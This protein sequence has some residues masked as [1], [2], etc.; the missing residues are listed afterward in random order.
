MAKI[1]QKVELVGLAGP[2]KGRRLLL[3]AAV[4]NTVGRADGCTVR[5]QGELV[6]EQHAVIQRNASRQW[7]ITNRSPYGTLVNGQATTETLLAPSSSIQVGQASLFRFEVTTVEEREESALVRGIRKRPLLVVAGGVYL[8]LMIAV[9]V[10]LSS[11]G[12]LAAQ[13]TVVSLEQI[14]LSLE[15]TDRYLMGPKGQL[16][17]SAERPDETLEAVRELMVDAWALERQERWR[18][19]MENYADVINLVPDLDAPVARLANR[20]MTVIRERI[21]TNKK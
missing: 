8:L 3:D 18:E 10:I 17:H 1:E 14:K 15:G 7:S 21:G 19:A 4:A 6:S 16:A 9:A 2:L 11:W 5:V 20:R 12:G 13:Q